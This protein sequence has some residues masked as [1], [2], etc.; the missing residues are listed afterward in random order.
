MGW[1]KQARHIAAE[2]GCQAARVMARPADI[3]N[4]IV[5]ALTHARFEL[6]AFSTVERITNAPVPWLTAGFAAAY[7][8]DS[9]CQERQALDGLL[10]IAVDHGERRCRRSSVCPSGHRASISGRPPPIS[11]G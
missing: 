1:S 11:Y 9:P 7:F 10:V 3:T 4:A 8:A 2:A 6:P 5:A